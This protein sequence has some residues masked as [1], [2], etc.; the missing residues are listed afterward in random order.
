[1]TYD[2]EG[3]L[4]PLGGVFGKPVHFLC[5]ELWRNPGFT[6]CFADGS[7]RIIRSD[8]DQSTI[9]GLISR[10]GEKVDLSKLE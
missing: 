7:A 1:V 4:P 9:R 2:P 3:P 6:A 5:Y 10:E 8:T